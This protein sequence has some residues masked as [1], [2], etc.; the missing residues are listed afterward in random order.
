MIIER[1]WIRAL[2]D[3]RGNVRTAC[4]YIASSLAVV[5]WGE[6]LTWCFV[7]RFSPSP[8]KSFFFNFSPFINFFVKACGFHFRGEP[9][10][11]GEFQQ[12]SLLQPKEIS[13]MTCC[14]KSGAVPQRSA[15]VYLTSAFNCQNK[16]RRCLCSNYPSTIAN[17]L[18]CVGSNNF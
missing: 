1:R 16:T 9:T 10:S 6:A 12:V 18:Y 15:N 17:V 5:A 8:C 14:F 3:L 2:S 11:N 7:T 4:C 13:A